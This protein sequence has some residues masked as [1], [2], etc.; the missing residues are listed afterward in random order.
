MRI[1]FD[2]S[3]LVGG[4]SAGVARVAACSLERLEARAV[5]DVVRLVPAAGE[6]PARFRRRLPALVREH[7]LDGVHTFASASPRGL[8]VPLVV[9]LH[10]LPWRHGVAEHAGWRHRI[11]ALL[12]ANRAARIVV[13][14]EFVARDLG[15]RARSRA[16][17]V[18]WGFGPPFAVEP[19][20]GVVD[21]AVLERFRLG[22]EPF[23][24]AP[25]AT[26]EKKRLDLVLAGM[27]RLH[28]RGDLRL[29]LVVTGRETADLRRSLG[30]ASTAGL[31]RWISTLGEVTDDELA[32]LMRLAACVPVLSAS[33]GFALPVLEA[34]ASGT[35]VVVP[36]AS[37]QAEVAGA[38]G[39]V[40]DPRDADALADAFGEAVATR[41]RRRYALAES[42]AGRT[43]D[44]TAE[45]LEALWRE[46]AP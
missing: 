14:T 38:A 15:R 2:A 28:R 17:V 13:P 18:P 9:T 8:G 37:A 7:R 35:P 23:L 19:P 22:A 25:G 32:A 46:L 5:L 36:P 34:L 40:V 41:G 1:G 27:E 4:F 44:R 43:W 20:P 10:E 30:Q 26:R 33:E 29:G 11:A 3:P 42:V 21:E 24:L 12:A 16:R 6:P 31:N 45:A 39:T